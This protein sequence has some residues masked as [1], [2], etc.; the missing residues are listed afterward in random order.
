[1]RFKKVTFNWKK[2]KFENNPSVLA[3]EIL[4]SNLHSIL[5]F[6]TLTTLNPWFNLRIS[7]SSN[8][9]EEESFFFNNRN[10][11]LE[12]LL[13]NESENES[14]I[15]FYSL[16]STVGCWVEHMRR[17]WQSL[18][19]KLRKRS[20]LNPSS[21]HFFLFSVVKLFSCDIIKGREI[22]YFYIFISLVNFHLVFMGKY[23]IILFISWGFFFSFEISWPSRRRWWEGEKNCGWKKNLFLL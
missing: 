10:H 22:N 7:K 4:L 12:F 11:K 9:F 6:L 1:M 13:R 21:F 2:N 19:L 18:T 8:Y 3:C 5:I 20:S 15:V 16:E 23:E 14:K 17:Y